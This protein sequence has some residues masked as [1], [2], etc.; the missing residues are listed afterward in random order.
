M[1]SRTTYTS[2]VTVPVYASWK[3][4]HCGEINFSAGNIVCRRTESTSSWRNSKHEEAKSKAHQ[5]AQAEWA[6]DA[7][8]IIN[9]PNHN[10]MAMYSS[11]FLQNTS[12]TQCKK[13]P[14]WEKHAKF[15][16]LVGLAMPVALISG[17]IAFASLTSLSAWL[18]FAC[19]AGFIVWGIAREEIY[20]KMM[21]N[22]PKQY[23]PV[24]GSLN[25]ELIEYANHLGATIPSPDGCIE[26]AKNYCSNHVT[27]SIPVDSKN[28]SSED[29]NEMA[30]AGFCRKCGTQLQVGSEFC[31]KCGTQIIK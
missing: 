16:P 10:A 6:G 14:R 12:C 3:C 1:G 20:K 28:V 31:H 18:V 13:K 22:Y 24:I 19:S 11:F 23:T 8:R 15:L 2:T 9:D 26:I 29:V 21:P 25:A 4:E 30:S 27:T 5:L 17:I 7:Y